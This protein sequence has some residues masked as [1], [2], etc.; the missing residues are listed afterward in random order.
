MVELGTHHCCE[1]ALPAVCRPD[2]NPCDASAGEPGARDGHFERPH[3]SGAHDLPAIPDGASAIEFSVSEAMRE[4]VGL[5]VVA[6]GGSLALKECRRLGGGDRAND[7]VQG[8]TPWVVAGGRE[9]GGEVYPARKRGGALPGEDRDGTR[10]AV[11]TSW[12]VETLMVSWR[13]GGWAVWMCAA[14]LPA[15]V[16]CNGMSQAR[17]TT[18]EPVAPPSETIAATPPLAATSGGA[19]QLE[20]AGILTAIANSAGL[21]PDDFE[22]LALDA[23][24]WPDGCLGL[25]EPGQVCSQARVAGW[26]AVVKMPDGTERGFR[27][28][29]GRVVAERR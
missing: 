29:A 13:R 21:A 15:S 26:R 9:P 7:V 22:L 19:S 6:E 17:S 20:A 1:D 8:R 18:G 16:A 2:G 3:T 28:G 24:T 27:G 25:A 4:E 11:K 12:R 10:V 23:A 5:E 14:I